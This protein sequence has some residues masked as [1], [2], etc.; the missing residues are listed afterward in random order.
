[1][2]VEILMDRRKILKKGKGKEGGRKNN[3]RKRKTPWSHS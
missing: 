2:A 3:E 1:M